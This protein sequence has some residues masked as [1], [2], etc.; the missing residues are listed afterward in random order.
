MS[1]EQLEQQLIEVVAVD[2][3]VGRQHAEATIEFRGGQLPCFTTS[4]PRDQQPTEWLE[5]RDQR[6]RL[7]APAPCTTR[8]Y[9]HAT[10]ITCE[11]LQDAARITIRPMV[12]HE[13]RLQV[14]PT[15]RR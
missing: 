1:R 5:N 4:A 13:S 14:H 8:E 11:Q 15:V 3:P 7:V 9:G 2:E 10:V 6:G 12:Q